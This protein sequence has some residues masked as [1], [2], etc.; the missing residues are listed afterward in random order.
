MEGIEEYKNLSCL[1]TF[2]KVYPEFIEGL[3]AGCVKYL[4]LCHTSLDAA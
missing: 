4:I 1:S 3:S 2:D